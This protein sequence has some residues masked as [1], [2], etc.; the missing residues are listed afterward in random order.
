MS[1]G[2]RRR[3]SSDPGLLWL[4]YRPAATAPIG[5]LAW[6]PL[7]AIGSALKEKDKKILLYYIRLTLE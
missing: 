6:E 7:Y 2:V 4:W 5:A 3:L 1:C